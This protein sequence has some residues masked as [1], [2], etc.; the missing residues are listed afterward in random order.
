[1]TPQAWPMRHF[2]PVWDR[3]KNISV[4]PCV[5]LPSRALIFSQKY[6]TQL[7]KSKSSIDLWIFLPSVDCVPQL[8]AGFLTVLTSAQTKIVGSVEPGLRFPCQYFCIR[9]SATAKGNF[10][11]VFNAVTFSPSLLNRLSGSSFSMFS[12]A[13]GFLLGSLLALGVA[14]L[15]ASCGGGGTTPVTADCLPYT[16]S[17]NNPVSCQEMANLAASNGGGGGGDG[18]GD[19][20]ADGSAGDGAPIAN[21]KLRFVDINNRVIETSTDANGYFRIN[22]R[23]M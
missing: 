7:T 20:G 21:T 22:L 14:L 18:S 12:R 15:I 11:R 8:L 6:L 2:Q 10:M 5:V 16:D 23:G 1:M 3:I 4:N 19:A 17:F 9:V 13:S